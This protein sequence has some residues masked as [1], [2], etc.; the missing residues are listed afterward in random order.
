MRKVLY[1]LFLCFLA[2]VCMLSSCDTMNITIEPPVSELTSEPTGSFETMTNGEDT[3]PA[4]TTEQYLP[5]GLIIPN[6]MSSAYNGIS[7]M[8]KVAFVYD[9]DE[10]MKF[11]KGDLTS[12]VYPAS[13]T[14]LYTALVALEYLDPKAVIT[15]GDEIDLRMPD[16]S[17][18]YI[19]K[20]QKLTVEMLVEAMMLPSGNDAAYAL[21]T[22]AGRKIRHDSNASP[23]DAIKTFMMA[24]NARA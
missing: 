3:T 13:V 17:V 12:P 22:A 2:A 18:A 7:L 6:F 10:G 14:K 8:S 4:P 1:F 19:S 16:S 15:I 9:V 5:A 23:K 24:V 20:G 21:A 11:Y